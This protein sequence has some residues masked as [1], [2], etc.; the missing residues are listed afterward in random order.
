MTKKYEINVILSIGNYIQTMRFLNLKLFRI[1][2]YGIIIITHVQNC[3]DL[4]KIRHN[5]N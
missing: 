5:H 3:T 2:F 4:K 1:I